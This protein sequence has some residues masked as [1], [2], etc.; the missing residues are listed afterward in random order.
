[1][2]LGY[3]GLTTKYSTLEEDIILSA[4]SGFEVVELRD[5]KLHDYLQFHSFKD[6]RR[7]LKKNNIEAIALN[8]MEI[9]SNT[10]KD[11][12][13]FFKKFE[14]LVDAAVELSSKY[15]VVAPMVNEDKTDREILFKDLSVLF[16]DMAKC[17]EKKSNVKIG[18]EYI[19]H[20]SAMVKNLNEAEQL[21]K[22]IDCANVG[23][24]IDTF[25]F[26][27]NGSDI[28]NIYKLNSDKLLMVH[29]ND[30][31]RL[32]GQFEEKD[33][34]YPG[35]GVAPMKEWLDAFREIGFDG[36][37]TVELIDAGI[38]GQNTDSVIQKSYETIKSV[39]YSK[40]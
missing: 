9:T 11:S 32:Y 36:V 21:R 12:T 19:S 8:S 25:A 17:A 33:R 15:I 5:Y 6:L 14:Y 29:F 1:M 20:P 35:E 18:L 28:N 23:L 2:I 40:D 38:W 13:E 10:F 34:T 7:L 24:V 22:R 30:S 4:K 37:Y 27:A 31:K 26:Y 3:N 16:K 39:L